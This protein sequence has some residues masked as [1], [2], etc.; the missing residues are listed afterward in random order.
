[1]I[2]RGRQQLQLRRHNQSSSAVAAA[3]AAAAAVAAAAPP[4]ETLTKTK[5]YLVGCLA[6]GERTSGGVEGSTPRAGDT[7]PAYGERCA[8]AMSL[9]FRYEIIIIIIT[10]RNVYDKLRTQLLSRIRGDPR[11]ISHDTTCRRGRRRRRAPFGL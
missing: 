1:M 9:L 6:F 2:R 5:Y 11:P 4:A 10:S 7:T 8:V 3:A